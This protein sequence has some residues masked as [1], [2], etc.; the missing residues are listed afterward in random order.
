MGWNNVEIKVETIIDD[1]PRLYIQRIEK[2]MELK[3]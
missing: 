3:D 2:F 1:N